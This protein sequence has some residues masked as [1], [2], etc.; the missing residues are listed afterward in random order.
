MPTGIVLSGGTK[1]LT[2][3]WTPCDEIDYAGTIIQIATSTG[4]PYTTA[5]EINGSTASIGGLAQ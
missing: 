1:Q 3:K 2:V 4:G 5:G